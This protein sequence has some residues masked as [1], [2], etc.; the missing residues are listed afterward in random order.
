MFI[1]YYY[2]YVMF[3]CFIRKYVPLYLGIFQTDIDSSVKQ[4]SS[5]TFSSTSVE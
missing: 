2:D 1:T 4:V 3:H 5:M